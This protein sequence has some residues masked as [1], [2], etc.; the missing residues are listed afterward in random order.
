MFVD[1]VITILLLFPVT[2]FIKRTLGIYIPFIMV[3]VL[4]SNIDDATTLIGDPTIA[5]SFCSASGFQFSPLWWALAFGADLG[6]NRT[7][8]GSM[9]WGSS[10]SIKRKIWTSHILYKVDKN[11]FSIYGNNFGNWN[12]CSI[13]IPYAN[14]LVQVKTLLP[15]V[16]NF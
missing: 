7:L 15:P 14:A 12:S 10:C 9:A 3:Q 11:M 2:F 13:W 6:G 8:I 5:A 1:N 4:V 16:V